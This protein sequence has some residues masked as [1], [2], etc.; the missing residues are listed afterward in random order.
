MSDPQLMRDWPEL[1]KVVVD[2]KT[3]LRGE[4]PS[5]SAL[6]REDG[7]MCCLGFAS[8]VC[9]YTTEQIFEKKTPVDAYSSA[10]NH[11]PPSFINVIEDSLGCKTSVH[12]ELVSNMMAINDRKL[13]EDA[14]KV[15]ELDG[16]DIYITDEEIREQTLV[17][18]GRKVGL[19]L[20]FVD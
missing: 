5:K 12:N 16:E 7:K 9:G 14:N 19:E 18:L 10:G 8:R 20:Q 17:K 6:L 4:G 13:E 3:W 11:Y 1:V 15:F 2:R